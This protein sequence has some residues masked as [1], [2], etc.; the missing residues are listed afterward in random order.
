MCKFT[1]KLF[2]VYGINLANTNGELDKI[3]EWLKINK[4]SLNVKKKNT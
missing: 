4:L 2:C 1:A 3:S